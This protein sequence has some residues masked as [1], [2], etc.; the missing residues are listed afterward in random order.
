MNCEIE[1][2]IVLSSNVV[3]SMGTEFIENEKEDVTKQ[4]CEL[5][6]AKRLL[7]RIKK[8]YPRLP[9]LIQGD[10]LYAIE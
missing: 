7:D 10:A 2:K 3:I 6:A 9:I 1:Y 8:E 4:D 5:N